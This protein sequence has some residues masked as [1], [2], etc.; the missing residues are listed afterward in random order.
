MSG[1]LNH[2]LFLKEIDNK[3]I[4]GKIKM[5]T[6][7]LREFRY[8]SKKKPCLADDAGE[9]NKNIHRIVRWHSIFLQNYIRRYS[10]WIRESNEKETTERTEN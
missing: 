9:R 5:A 10:L 8:P 3:S 4:Q 1:K 2:L 7:L 6:K